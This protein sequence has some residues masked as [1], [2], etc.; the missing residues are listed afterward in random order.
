MTHS[1]LPSPVPYNTEPD[2]IG[3]ALVLAHIVT[4]ELS[5]DRLRKQKARQ[6]VQRKMQARRIRVWQPWRRSTGPKSAAGKARTRF[7]ANKHGMRSSKFRE[8][9]HLLRLQSRFVRGINQLISIGYFSNSGDFPLTL[10]LP[11]GERDTK[12]YTGEAGLAG[13]G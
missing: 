12:A 4:N 9:R 5:L 3:Q 13:V 6:A 10:P 1:A 8:L 2:R 11:V 7:N